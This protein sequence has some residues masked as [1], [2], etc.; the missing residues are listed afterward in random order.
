MKVEEVEDLAHEDIDVLRELDDASHGD[1][2]VS[3]T[4][5]QLRRRIE[6]AEKSYHVTY[7]L[8]KLEERGMIDT[9][10]DLERGPSNQLPPRVAR[11][12]DKGESIAERVED[13]V[14]SKELEDRVERL[15]HL[16]DIRGT[17]SVNMQQRIVESEERI[18][19][20]EQENRHLREDVKKLRRAVKAHLDSG[21]DV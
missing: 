12:T 11:L 18:D 19:E 7:R 1:G 17:R 5:G 16:A 20:L 10:K 15:E 9:R 21:G 8:D 4:T 3:L 14:E 2:R 6:W 13:R